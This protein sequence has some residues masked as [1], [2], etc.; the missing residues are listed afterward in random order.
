LVFFVFPVL[1]FGGFL[2]S[3]FDTDCR[4]TVERQLFCYQFFLFNLTHAL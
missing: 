1:L 3:G 2:S 4:L